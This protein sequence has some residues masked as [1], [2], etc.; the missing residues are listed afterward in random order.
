M[1]QHTPWQFIEKETFFDQKRILT[2][3]SE[4]V[5]E[6]HYYPK[7]A[8]IQ[9]HQPQWDK[10]Q[11]FDSLQRDSTLLLKQITSHPAPIV[12]HAGNQ[13]LELMFAACGEL[14]LE[15]RDTQL[16]FSL[17]TPN[18]AISYAALVKHY[19]DIDLNKAETRSDWL[20]RPL[21]QAQCDY[22]ADDVGLLSQL[23]PYLCAELAAKNRL[24]WWQEDCASLLA[25][26]RQPTEAIHWYKLRTAPQQ[27]RKSH[28]P[29][30]EALVQIR[31]TLA[32][33]TDLPRRHIM[34][35]EQI[36]KLARAQPRNA[37]ELAEY[38]PD[39]HQIFSDI[40]LVEAAFRDSENLPPP[41]PRQIRLTDNQLQQYHLADTQLKNL[42]MELDIHPDTIATSRQLREYISTPD[43]ASVSQGWRGQLLA[44][45]KL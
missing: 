37:A 11:I 26:Q 25:N 38:L 23:Y 9:L 43:I 31:E 20:A 34:P 1:K 29:A 32:Q 10:A 15:I 8:L 16:G 3:D 24:H 17:L 30:A 35:D 4:F 45:L 14:P 44:Q 42:A 33:Q 28:L 7:L 22:A 39:N 13:D 21:S 2:Y 40:A 6:K 41:K 12:L 18:R 27:L 19:L 5:R 36:V